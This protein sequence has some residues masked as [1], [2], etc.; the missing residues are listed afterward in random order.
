[1][2]CWLLLRQILSSTSC[3]LLFLR[4]IDFTI[5]RTCRGEGEGGWCSHATVRDTR[6]IEFSRVSGSRLKVS[7]VFSLRENW[8]FYANV[9]LFN[10]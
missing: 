9:V 10:I 8:S 3:S 4:G 2:P 6:Q 5:F 7:G 1:M